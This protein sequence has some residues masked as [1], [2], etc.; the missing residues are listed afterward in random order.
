M[1]IYV[2]HMSTFIVLHLDT[3]SKL[4]HKFYFSPICWQRASCLN[5][6]YWVIYLFPLILT[7]TCYVPCCFLQQ[8]SR[9]RSCSGLNCG[10]SLLFFLGVGIYRALNTTIMLTTNKIISQARSLATRWD[11]SDFLLYISTYQNETFHFAHKT[12][13]LL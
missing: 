5:T 9:Y 3:W 4:F 6:C 1:Y 13:F 7:Q 8:I 11:T 2:Y 10:Y 12:W